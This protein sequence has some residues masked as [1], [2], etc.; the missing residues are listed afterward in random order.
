MISDAVKAQGIDWADALRTGKE[1]VACDLATIIFD[2]SS[3][4]ARLEELGGG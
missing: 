4:K 3:C 1:P 2:L